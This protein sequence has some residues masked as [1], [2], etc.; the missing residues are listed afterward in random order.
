MASDYTASHLATYIINCE[1]NLLRS[2]GEAYAV[3]RTASGVKIKV[4]R[5]EGAQHGWLN[6]PFTPQGAQRPT[7]IVGSPNAR[8]IG[9]GHLPVRLRSP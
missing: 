6:L 5:I 7:L 2:S 8:A 4:E 1:M 3:Q 9:T